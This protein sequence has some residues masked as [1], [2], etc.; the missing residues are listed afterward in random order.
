MDID[1]NNRAVLEELRLLEKAEA[2]LRD[3]Q[4]AVEDSKRHLM[5]HILKDREMANYVL[6]INR[7]KLKRWMRN[8]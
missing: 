2:A 1:S 3:A 7:S 5:Q 8:N 4:C 6:S